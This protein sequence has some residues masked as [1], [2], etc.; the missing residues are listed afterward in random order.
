[1]DDAAPVISDIRRWRERF[2]GMQVLVVFMA[3]S[4][5]AAAVAFW[6]CCR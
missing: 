6:K 2:I 5:G 1:M 4:A 3:G